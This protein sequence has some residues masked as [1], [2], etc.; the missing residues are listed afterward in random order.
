[1]TLRVVGAG[2][3]RTGTTSLTP[4][5]NRPGVEQR[6][7]RTSRRAELTDV[8]GGCGAAWPSQ[9]AGTSSSRTQTEPLDEGCLFLNARTPTTDDACRP[10]M[11]AT[12]ELN[13]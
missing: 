8:A 3:G 4:K 1:M 5:P 6:W 7:R 10:L 11:V 13:S 9:P 2:L 12:T